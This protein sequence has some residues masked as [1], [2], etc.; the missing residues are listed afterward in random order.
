[1][2]AI[3]VDSF[4]LKYVLQHMNI[5]KYRCSLTCHQY[6]PVIKLSE[7]LHLPKMERLS[8]EKCQGKCYDRA[9][10]P[11]LVPKSGYGHASPFISSSYIA[12]SFGN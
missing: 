11:R 6:C 12:H 8:E 5:L 1:M 7:L 9:F 3:L 2:L 4:L 10:L